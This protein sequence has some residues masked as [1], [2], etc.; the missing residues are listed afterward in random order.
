MKRKILPLIIIFLMSSC[1]NN[2][3]SFSEDV[4]K[5]EE[6]LSSDESI[7]SEDNEN[8]PSFDYI[9]EDNENL[10]PIKVESKNLYEL[11]KSSLS[12]QGLTNLV[13][14]PYSSIY[15]DGSAAILYPD[16]QII[17]GVNILYTSSWY[18]RYTYER[19]EDCIEYVLNRDEDQWYVEDISNTSS[20]F[21]P[22]NQ[23]VLSIPKSCSTTYQIGDLINFTKGSIP[24]YELGLYNEKGNRI[25]V[26]NVNT[27]TYSSSGVTLYD[28]NYLNKV[29]P[30][31]WDKI[32]LLNCYYDDEKQA[33][34]VDKFRN[35]LSKGRA[36]TNVFNGFVL[37]ATLKS[38]NENCS[39]INDVRFSLKD[40]IY[41]E[42]NSALF[43][44]SFNFSLNSVNNYTF[45]NGSTLSFEI[46][47]STSSTSDS[48][49]CFEVL[50]NSNNVIIESGSHIN[51]KDNGYKLILKSANGSK[52]EDVNLLLDNVFTR[53]S[54]IL[55]NNN[56]LT[57]LSSISQRLNSF[58]KITNDYLQEV[59][60]DLFTYNYSYNIDELYEINKRMG[61]LKE[62]IDSIS[63]INNNPTMRYYL[64]TLLGKVNQEYFNILSATNRNEA[65]M[66]KTC[67]YIV[68]FTNYDY[69]LDTIKKHLDI[70]K[71]AGF[72]EI[73]VNAM[74]K[75]TVYY[76][77]SKIY[78]QNKTCASKN[79]DEYGSDFLKA[80]TNEAHKRNI[81]VQACFTPFTNG[82]ENN[83]T[84][85]KDAFALSIE[86]KD[87]VLTSQGLVKMLDPANSQVQQRIKETID[88]ILISN[89]DLDGIHL[90]YIRYGADN[91]YV[92]TIMGVTSSALDGFNKY[93]TNSAF[94]CETLDE[95]KNKLKTDTAF[96]SSFNKYQQEL[97][98]ST[99]ANI[100]NVC[101]NYDVPLTCAVADNYKYVKTWKCQDF[102]TWAKENLV[103]ALYLMDY[104]F[105]EYWINH[106]FEDL[107]SATNNTSLLVTGIDPSYANLIAEYYPKTL[108]GALT[109]ANSMGYGIFG[110]HT[111]DAKKDGWDLV[112]YTNWI[113]SIS[114]YDS[115]NKTIKASCDLL[116][117]RCDNIYL[118]F[119]NQTLAQKELL[120][121]DVTVLL[122]LAKEDSITTCENLLDQLEIM[123]NKVYANN[124]ANNRINEQIDYMIKIVK[125]KLN[126]IK[127]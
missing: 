81:M 49:W 109:N 19:S 45:E 119:D 73:I 9:L 72:N 101:K 13:T 77:N 70:I 110:S 30:T 106:Y 11:P 100:K 34:I 7:T 66:V 10:S 22:F 61:T 78:S 114:P 88:D 71:N 93:T 113:D 86:G 121:N 23:A 41:V 58:Y 2:Q 74:E 76:N 37:A 102:G 95:L 98:T 99:V 96:F 112:S 47:K 16:N 118:A 125:A 42:E 29:T 51:V 89:P 82:I 15:Y 18:S 107:V 105:D 62:K 115:L 67:W 6:A 65:V 108:K 64:H 87:S 83:F 12:I 46:T 79:Y 85:L 44:K 33:F 97:I 75:G 116:L 50:V 94:K 40:K 3:D 92:N 68:D 35:L 127:D 80:I 120:N 38:E 54:R 90:D 117:T 31:S 43:D 5:S 104:Y 24:L 53:G 36:Y 111:Q 52:A 63:K 123:K 14:N 39:I 124:E 28:S 55:I 27:P 4:S 21:I 59:L 56:S 1:Q 48:A 69:N 32:S 20:T 60:D 17:K 84:E 122:S 103:D 25:A 57:I 26:S 126:I 91:S 8:S